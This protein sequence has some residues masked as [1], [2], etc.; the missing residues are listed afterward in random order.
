MVGP[1]LCAL[2]LALSGSALRAARDRAIAF[3]GGLLLVSVILFGGPNAMRASDVTGLFRASAAARLIGWAAWLLA[4]VPLSRALLVMPPTFAV[5]SLPVARLGQLGVHGSHLA[6]AQLPWLVLWGR[7]EGMGSGLAMLVTAVAAEALLVARSRRPEALLAALALATLV[8]LGVSGL[9][10]LPV[11]AAAAG[12]GLAE[13]WRRA[14]ELASTSGARRLRGPGWLV[15]AQALGLALW[16]LDRALLARALV[17]TA[18]G[19]ALACAAILNNQVRAPASIA[20][21]AL[22]VGAAPLSVAGMAAAGAVVARAPRERWLLDALG[23]RAPVRAA[24]QL[25]AV[26]AVALLLGAA[27]GLV[28][29]S[30]AGLAPL[31]SARLVVLL[32]AWALALA[33]AALAVARWAAVRAAR[34]RSVVPAMA[35]VVASAALAGALAGEAAVPVAVVAAVVAACLDDGAGQGAVVARPGLAREAR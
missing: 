18:A 29:A 28:V 33:A 20:R 22:A 32:A 34:A 13:A 31:A 19:A 25:F 21:V 24:G 7:G 8:A 4:T 10:A 5:R 2:F 17:M 27:A 3:Y 14:P 1:S 16:R 11:A 15:L 26:G 9:A 12:V 30:A 35:G 23:V 6:V